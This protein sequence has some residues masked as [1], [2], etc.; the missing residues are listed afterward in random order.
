M[1]ECCGILKPVVWKVLKIA[2]AVI[3]NFPACMQWGLR[4][5]ERQEG[6]RR[7]ELIF[8]EGLK[9]QM[10]HFWKMMKKYVKG[11]LQKI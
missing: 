3:R 11:I 10:A 8:S 4:Q 7:W 6:E 5:E 1:R 9:N 2:E